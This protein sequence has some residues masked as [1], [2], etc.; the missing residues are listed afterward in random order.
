MP[1]PADLLRT[2]LT[3]DP[4]RPLVTFYDDATGERTEL[5]VA[6]FGNWVAKTA[7][8]LTSELGLGAGS[9]LGVA[10]P[11]HWQTLV[12]VQAAW[13]VGVLAE[14]ASSSGS[15]DQDVVVTTPDGVP[16]VRG[17]QAVALSL[18]PALEAARGPATLPWSAVDGETE[19]LGQPD[20]FVASPVPAPQAP[21]LALGDRVWSL[22]ELVQAGRQAAQRVGAGPGSRI[23]TALPPE[24]LEGVTAALLV[25]LAVR[26]SVVLCRNLDPARLDARVRAERV[27]VVV[28]NGSERDRGS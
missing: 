4:A 13:T 11:L 7:G 22:E 15:L 19:V 21:G 24:S 10:L 12:Y 26:G 23:L 9:R 1:T 14:V 16:G 8:L 17:G 5:S 3:D 20:A 25:P 28:R 6:T 18:R 2:A 27:D